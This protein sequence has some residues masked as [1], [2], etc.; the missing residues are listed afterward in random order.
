MDPSYNHV[1]YAPIP[2]LDGNIVTHFRAY[3]T[4][5]DGADDDNGDGTPA[6]WAIPHWVAYEIKSYDGELGKYNRPSPWITVKELYAEVIAP[7][8]ESYRF[9][10]KFREE[11]PDSP[12]LGYDR[13]HMC[14]K[15][16]ALPGELPER[17]GG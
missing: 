11:N 12:Q 8:D 5:F 3:T 16:H 1:K 7:K 13:G 4:C 14:M 10:K 6:Q 9:S 15:H 2:P 17:A